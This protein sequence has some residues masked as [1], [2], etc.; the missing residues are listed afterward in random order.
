MAAASRAGF[1]WSRQTLPNRLSQT[2]LRRLE[3]LV[4]IVEH[5]IGVLQPV[6]LVGPEHDRD[7]FE[8]QAL[9]ILVLERVLYLGGRGEDARAIGFQAFGCADQAEL[10][11]VPVE[12]GQQV[13]LRAGLNA[14]L[15]VGL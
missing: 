6:D 3:E 2:R 13:D 4:E 9:D 7:R 8:R 5:E 12:P 1:P 11:R 10:D 14:A 15:A